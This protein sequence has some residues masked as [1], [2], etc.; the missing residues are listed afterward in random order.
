MANNI[1]SDELLAAFLD[2]NTDEKETRQVLKA[3]KT[4]PELQET[5]DIIICMESRKKPPRTTKA[6][7]PSGHTTPCDQKEAKKITKKPAARPQ[8]KVMNQM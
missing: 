2:G 3:I 4:D 5:L 8:K 7:N 1:I 6:A